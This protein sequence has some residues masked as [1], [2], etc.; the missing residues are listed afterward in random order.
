VHKGIKL[1]KRGN[2][3][4]SVDGADAVVRVLIDGLE[5]EAALQALRIANAEAI[6]SLDAPIRAKKL[7]AP[8]AFRTLDSRGFI[9]MEMTD[10]GIYRYPN[11]APEP[12]FLFYLIGEDTGG[13]K[14]CARIELVRQVIQ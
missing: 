4:V 12:E 7:Q 14:V 11:P 8:I 13:R 2:S 5:D 6:R 9:I 10:R 3:N 1:R